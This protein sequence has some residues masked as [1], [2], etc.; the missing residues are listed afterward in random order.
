MF[1]S[2]T[3]GGEALSLAAAIAT[4][5][6]IEKE[7]GHRAAVAGRRRL[8]RAGDQKDRRRRSKRGDRACRQGPVGDPRL[9][10]PPNGSKEAIKTLFL[11]EMIAAGVLV[12]A[13]HN[14]CLCSYRGR[15]RPVLA[16]YCHALAVLREA[17]DRGDISRRLGNQVIRPIFTVRAT[18]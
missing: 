2:G 17:L 9:Q 10:G 13:S 7:K 14:V 4:V 16:A 11:R 3:F 1:F 6:K 5:D 15:Y 18:G 12:N 8:K